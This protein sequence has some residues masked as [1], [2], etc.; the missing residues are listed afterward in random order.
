MVEGTVE[1]RKEETSGFCSIG[2]PLPR[3]IFLYL[4]LRI[5]NKL[6]LCATFDNT[7]VSKNVCPVTCAL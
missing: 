3:V 1:S 4:I 5:I 6:S 2:H 7:Q